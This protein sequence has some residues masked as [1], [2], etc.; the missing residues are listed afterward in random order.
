MNDRITLRQTRD[1][2]LLSAI[3]IRN[4]ERVSTEDERE[5]ITPP[6]VFTLRIGESQSGFGI[7]L[8]PTLVLEDSRCPT[9]VVCIQAGT[10]LLETSF[11]TTTGSRSQVFVLG[12]PIKED[13]KTVVLTEVRPEALSGDPIAS[14]DYQFVFSVTASEEVEN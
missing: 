14:E 8:T 7:S 4:E 13:G 2:L 11:Q 6:V 5:G 9:D 1:V 10:V 12:E 3:A